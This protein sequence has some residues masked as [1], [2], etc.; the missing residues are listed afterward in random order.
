VR[1]ALPPLAPFFDPRRIRAIEQRRSRPGWL[2]RMRIRKKL[3]VLH[4][5]FTI[6][7]A[8]ALLL[9]LRPAVTAVVRE[10]EIE[11][12]VLLLGVLGEAESISSRTLSAE[13]ATVVIETGDERTLGLLQEDAT[14]A[15]T[16]A[17]ADSPGAARA[18]AVRTSV[19][20]HGA[21]RFLGPG[22]LDAQGETSPRFVLLTARIPDAREAVGR[23]YMFVVVALVVIY[24]LVAIALELFVLPQN[25]YGPIQRMLDADAAL[26]QGRRDSEIIEEAMIPKDEMGEIMRS[27]NRSIAELRKKEAD[28]GDALMRL[29]EV[30]TDLKR[31]NHLLE[32]AK[33]NL[34]DADRLASLGMMSA[35]VAHELNTPLAV[36]KGLTERLHASP[37]KRLEPADAALML[38]VVHRLER[39]GESL[40]DY[41]RVRTPRSA[42]AACHTIVHEAITLVRLDRDAGA[43]AIENRV[44]EG[45]E[46]FC[47]ADR[48]VQVFV[49]LIRNA[50]DALRE[51][52]ARG[53][54]RPPPRGGGGAGCKARRGSRRR[55]RCLGSR[56]RAR[57]DRG[58]R[59]G[60]GIMGLGLIRRS[61]R[62]C[63]SRSRARGW[64]ARGRGWGWRWRRGSCESTGACFWRRIGA[65][66][67]GRC[68]RCCCR[69]P[70][71]SEEPL[72]SIIAHGTRPR[73]AVQR[74]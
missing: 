30:A 62:G 18:V 20:G 34:Q 58:L 22:G 29:E 23:L 52:A 38:R 51:H 72:A 1:G 4:S 53:T 35:G 63:L 40:L 70:R 46:A 7:L 43:I 67:Q 19:G 32:A 61:C 50:V 3:I 28:L 15:R 14:R 16:V 13:D 42:S 74:F 44:P 12:A 54:R 25:V 60:F 47:D 48:M 27:R 31:K 56:S 8:A 65:I 66:G 37:E 9:T 33:R 69:R 2:A 57:G 55:S 73:R 64:T 5:V 10:A 6:I 24:L 21:V 26:R 41:A 45:L 36:V 39:L 68:L 71:P 17:S 59:C 11:K 49:N